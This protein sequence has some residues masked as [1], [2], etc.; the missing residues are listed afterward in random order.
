MNDIY[1][2]NRYF[3]YGDI[4]DEMSRID[5]K[6]EEE[7]CKSDSEYDREKEFNLI[8]QQFLTGMKLNTGFKLF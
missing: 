8:Y 3:N 1:Y 5:E 6:L 2:R 4:L 7:R